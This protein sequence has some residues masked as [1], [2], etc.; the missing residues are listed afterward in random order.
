MVRGD[1]ESVL[2]DLGQRLNACLCMHLGVQDLDGVHLTRH[3]GDDCHTIMSPFRVFSETVTPQIGVLE[4]LPATADTCT[5][6]R[7]SRTELDPRGGIDSPY[8]KCSLSNLRYAAEDMPNKPRLVRH[9]YNLPSSTVSR[10][11]RRYLR[12]S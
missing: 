3:G 7:K 9:L 10:R 6:L 11:L 12:P 1:W 5:I 4:S 2:R 8:S